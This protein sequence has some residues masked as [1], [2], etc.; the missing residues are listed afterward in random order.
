MAALTPISVVATGIAVPVST[1][2]S[3]SDT[4]ANDGNTLLIAKTSGTPSNLTIKSQKPCDQGTTHD[5]V[6]AL[7]ATEQKVI[8]KFSKERFNDANGLVTVESSSQTGLTY[9]VIKVV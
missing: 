3:A 1:A 5:V 2:A 8:G 6:V 4:F 7:A 9:S